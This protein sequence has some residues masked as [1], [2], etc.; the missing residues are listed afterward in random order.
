MV[1]PLRASAEPLRGCA[2]QPCALR[3][4]PRLELSTHIQYAS[5][6]LFCDLGDDPDASRTA[7]RVAI[8][9]AR[10]NRAVRADCDAGWKYTGKVLRAID[11]ALGVP[12]V[13][14]TPALSCAE[15]V[16]RAS[17][18]EGDCGS[19]LAAPTFVDHAPVRAARYSSGPTG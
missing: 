13:R 10:D 1:R 17:V 2:G 14:P 6:A 15:I 18:Y 19:E 3:T 11:A 5:T 4:A 8:V 16:P 7:L 9:N 12:P